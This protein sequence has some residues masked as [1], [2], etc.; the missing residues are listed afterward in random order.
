[1]AISYTRSPDKLNIAQSGTREISRIEVFLFV[2]F[3]PAVTSK[4]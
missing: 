3:F 2:C 1:M 4:Y